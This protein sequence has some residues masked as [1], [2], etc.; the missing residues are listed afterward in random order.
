MPLPRQ[1]KSFLIERFREMG[2][3]PATRHGQNFLIDLN[4]QQLIVNAAEI[5]PRDV[6]LEVGTGTGALTA[7]MADRAA[8]VV[9]VE[10]DHHLFEFAS[11]ELFDRPNV[12]ML[13]FDALR[14]KHNF[15]DRVIAAVGEQLA[16]HPGSQFKLVANLPYNIATPVIS[17]LLFWEHVP[18]AMIVT[19]QKELADRITA[20]PSSKDYGALSIWIQSQCKAEI[21]RLM[22]PQVFWPAPKVTS[23]VIRLTIEPERRAA[24]GDLKYFHDFTRAIFLHRRKFLRANVVAAMKEHLNKA[25]VDEV[26]NAME[27]AADTRTEQLDVETLLKLAD[28]VRAVAPEW[29]L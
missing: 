28:K 16:A 24:I 12:T 18:H 15:D 21:V 17:N 26:L 19:I 27:F 6:V 8:A 22:S 7:Q 3:A 14:N 20:A 13:H 1:T 5:G 4:L 11:E 25:Q 23:A 2:I 9:T 10:I 29:T